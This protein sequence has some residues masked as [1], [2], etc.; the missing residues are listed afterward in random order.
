[1]C[2]ISTSAQKIWMLK[3]IYLHTKNSNRL[4]TKSVVLEH[5]SIFHTTTLH[6][7]MSVESNNKKGNKI[8]NTIQFR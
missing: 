2:T 1:M 5:Y 6:N 7:K 3:L 8:K 4:L